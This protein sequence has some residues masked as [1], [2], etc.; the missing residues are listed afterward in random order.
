MYGSYPEMTIAMRYMAAKLE[1]IKTFITSPPEKK[2]PLTYDEMISIAEKI[3]GE[4]RQRIASRDNE[5]QP[6]RL[7]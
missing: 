6:L 2:W 1:R 7:L 3:S 4:S 5:I